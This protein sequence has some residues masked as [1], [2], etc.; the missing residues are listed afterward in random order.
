MPD[1]SASCE[2]SSDCPPYADPTPLSP[3]RG[4]GLG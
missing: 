4:E 1:K 2:D 3:S